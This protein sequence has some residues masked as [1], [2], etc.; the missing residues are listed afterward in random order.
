[1]LTFIF[2]LLI[3]LSIAAGVISGNVQELTEAVLNEPVNA[4]ELCIYLCG[5]MCFWGGL[6]RVAEK[7]GLTEKLAE[8]FALILGGLFKDL[9]KQ[10]RAFKAICM[11]ITANLLGLGNAATPF[12]IEAMKALAEEEEAKDTATP[13]MIIFTV[14]N[15][16]SLTLIPSTA[17]SLRMKYGSADPLEI[18]PAVWITSAA[19]LAV[20]VTLAVLPLSGKRKRGKKL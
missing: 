18:V 5:G 9:D 12:G 14:I 7:S 6:M 20:S 13:S 4:V 19:A 1:M 15:T 16:A 2:S 8:V 10:G 17:L 3:I 11:N